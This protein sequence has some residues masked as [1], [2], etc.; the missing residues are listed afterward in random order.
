MTPAN[1]AK[2]EW[3]A[4]RVAN[5]Q[6]GLLDLTDQKFVD[7]PDNMLDRHTVR[8]GDLLLA[9]AIGSKEHLGK[10]I[11]VYPG[12]RKWAFDSYIMRVRLNREHLR[13]RMVENAIGYPQ[14]ARLVSG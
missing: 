9:R 11:V 10:C 1:A 5:I 8:D 7:I 13:T 4:I 2:G 14:W 3:L 12:S 6:G